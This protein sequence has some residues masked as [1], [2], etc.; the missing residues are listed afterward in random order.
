MDAIEE[1]EKVEDIAV[2]AIVGE[3]FREHPNVLARALTALSRH[4]ISVQLLVSGA[5]AVSA[6]IV[7][8]R[9]SLGT[10]LASV[11]REFFGD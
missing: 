2:L 3:G 4:R 8:D 11:H 7:V 1:L 10:A 9:N 5:S 6:Y